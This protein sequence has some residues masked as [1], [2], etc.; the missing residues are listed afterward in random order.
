MRFKFCSGCCK[1]FHDVVEFEALHLDSVMWTDQLACAAACAFLH[2]YGW[3]SKRLR[4]YGV[5][6]ADEDAFV[7]THT[8]VSYVDGFAGELYDFN[9][10]IAKPELRQNGFA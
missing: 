7:A 6:G 9:S 5:V 4:G 1:S 2:V 10:V 3:I 8:L